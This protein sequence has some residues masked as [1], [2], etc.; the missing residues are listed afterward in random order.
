ML[1][2]HFDYRS[3]QRATLTQKPLVVIDSS[4]IIKTSKPPNLKNQK[5]KIHCQDKPNKFF[6]ALSNGSRD[7]ILTKD[8]NQCRLYIES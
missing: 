8:F 6:M 7:F 4:R 1:I 2:N 3:S 5:T